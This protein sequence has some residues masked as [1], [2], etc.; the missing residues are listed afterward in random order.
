MVC[1]DKEQYSKSKV[2]KKEEK[3][4]GSGAMKEKSMPW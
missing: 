1:G 3:K 4:K 2:Q